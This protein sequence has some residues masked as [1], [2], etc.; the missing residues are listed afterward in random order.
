M[1]IIAIK[2]VIDIIFTSCIIVFVSHL[3][4]VVLAPV[5]H[6]IVNILQFLPVSREL[7]DFAHL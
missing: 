5:P 3:I 2:H 6:C 7:Y 4:V 1:S